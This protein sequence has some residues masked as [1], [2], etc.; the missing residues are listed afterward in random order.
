MLGGVSAFDFYGEGVFPVCN[1]IHFK[2]P[3]IAEK[4][5]VSF[6]PLIQALL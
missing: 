3:V 1:G 5:Q 6:F 4:G 2:A